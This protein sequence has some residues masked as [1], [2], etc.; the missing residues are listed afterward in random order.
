M[1]RDIVMPLSWSAFELPRWRSHVEKL[2][3]RSFRKEKDY[4]EWLGARVTVFNETGSNLVVVSEDMLGEIVIK[5]E[6]EGNSVLK[7]IRTY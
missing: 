1:Y 3:G 6:T 2:A 5:K 4:M 7:A